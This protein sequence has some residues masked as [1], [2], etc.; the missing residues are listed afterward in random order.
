[1][2]NRDDLEGFDPTALTDADQRI[3][4]RMEELADTAGDWAE[5]LPFEA[6]LNY[7]VTD[8]PT[9]AFEEHVDSC[10][11]CQQLVE[12][13]GPSDAVLRELHQIA[14]EAVSKT[15]AQ[16][17]GMGDRK[18]EAET[19]PVAAVAVA[20]VARVAGLTPR[21]AKMLRMR[22]GIDINTDHTLEEVGKQ[23]DVTREHIRQIE[24]K[25]L[26]NISHPAQIAA[27]S[28]KQKAD[29]RY[30][31]LTQASDNLLTNSVDKEKS[32]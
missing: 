16:P 12:T 18:P 32:R 5:H 7:F 6:A 9:A 3:L 22:F 27:A 15:S 31:R 30:L 28:V 19:Q 11:Y 1:M 20:A 2:T 14:A 8:S 24:A 17:K 13:L 10:E 25:A 29:N 23:F 21:E 4:S 26:R